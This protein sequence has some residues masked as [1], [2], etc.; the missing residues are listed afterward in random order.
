MG[1]YSVQYLKIVFN[2]FNDVEYFFVQIKGFSENEMHLKIFSALIGRFVRSPVYG[3]VYFCVLLTI[4]SMN[5]VMSR[6]MMLFMTGA[7]TSIPHNFSVSA[8]LS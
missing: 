7:K 2:N 3:G 8:L 5:L 1:K 6:M 4:V